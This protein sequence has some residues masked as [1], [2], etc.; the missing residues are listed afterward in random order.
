MLRGTA[1]TDVIC[2][3]G[4]NDKI[5]PGGL[6]VVL[7]GAGNDVIY[8][9]NGKPDNISGGPG[10]DAARIDKGLDTVTS[11]ERLLP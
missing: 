2:G 3:L 10:N 6:D 4:G 8:A 7:A 11:V 5:F 1:R 9:R